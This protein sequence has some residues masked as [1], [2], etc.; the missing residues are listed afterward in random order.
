MADGSGDGNIVKLKEIRDTRRQ[1]LDPDA[2]VPGSEDA[3]ALEFSDQHA[4][5]LRWCN[6]WH[7]WLRW[8][9]GAW[10]LVQTLWIFN[11]VRIIA[12]EHARLLQDKRLG[13]DATVTAIERLARNDPRHDTSEDAW[14]SNSEFMNTPVDEKE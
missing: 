5:E 14:D 6:P 3:L 7:K 10:R 8:E 1:P 2:P 11:R 12:R 9:G 13:K 4:A